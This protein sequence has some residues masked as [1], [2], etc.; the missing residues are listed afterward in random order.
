MTTAMLD[1]LAGLSIQ[2]VARR[3][4]FSE[5]ALCYYE[6]TGLIDPVP[7]DSSSSH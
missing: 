4:G 6:R 2:E 7:R 1:D 5:S 3:T